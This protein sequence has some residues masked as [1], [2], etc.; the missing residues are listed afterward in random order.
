MS[1]MSH[2]VGEPNA[3]QR[4]AE[5][6]VFGNRPLVLILFAL[7]TIVLAF[8]AA[9]LR[10]DAGFKK[11]IPLNH[12]YMK[13]F[14]DYEQEFGGANRIL[15]AVMAKNG[16]MFTLPFMRTMENVTLAAK[17][18]DDVDEARLRSIF[19]PNVRFIEVVEDGLNAGNVIPAGFTPNLEGFDPDKAKFDEIRSN[20]VKAG[21]LGRLVAKD[22]SG[23]MI[24]VDLVPENPEQGV[25]VDYNKIAGQL[26]AIRSKYENAD[27]S[28]HIIGFAKMVGDITDGH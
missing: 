1:D 5:R 24:W 2:G 7:I 12:E 16:N 13:T 25:K 10:I 18:I 27:T 15:I 14:I 20:I 4:F 6:L 9:Q 22:F 8:F 21:I 19:T 26:E 11:Q 3:V 23:A 28:V 17:G